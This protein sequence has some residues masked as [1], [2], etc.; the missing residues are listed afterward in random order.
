MFNNKIKI[1]YSL[2][3]PKTKYYLIMLDIF[4]RREKIYIFTEST[5]QSKFSL[6]NCFILLKIQKPKFYNLFLIFFLDSLT[7]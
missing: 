2:L 3:S 5:I 4:S 7:K 6:L 1:N